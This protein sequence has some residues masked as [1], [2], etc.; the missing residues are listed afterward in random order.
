MYAPCVS[1]V[2]LTSIVQVELAATV[3]LLSFTEV[4]VPPTKALPLESVKVA[5]P[6]PVREIVTGLAT[7]TLVGKKSVSVVL[8]SAV[9]VS[10][11]VM[12][13]AKVLACPAV[14]V[15][16]EKLLLKDGG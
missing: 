13:I 16:G 1:D 10:V 8:V 5:E 12:T 2:T 14:T 15:L 6:Q 7:I 11:L 9:T 3:P 4:L